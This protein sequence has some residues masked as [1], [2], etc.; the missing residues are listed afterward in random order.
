MLLSNLKPLTL[1][2]ISVS[3]LTAF[4]AEQPVE[5]APITILGEPITSPSFNDEPASNNTIDQPELIERGIN[6]IKNLSSQIANFH[7]T[8]HGIGSFGKI[9]SLRGLSDTGIFSTPSVVFYVDDVPYTSS[10][11]TMGRL[12]NI[13]SV[14]VYRSAQPGRFGKNAYAGA[15][16]IKSQQPENAIAS[17]LALELGNYSQHQ[18][19]AD[20]SGALLK[21][22]LFYSVSGNFQQRDGFLY[23]SFLNTTPDGQNLFSGR[24][25]LSWR[26]TEQWDIRLT[27]L[28]EDFDFGATRLV[29]LDS[30]D[31]YTVQS[32]ITEQLKQQADTQALR[33]AYHFDH[34]ELLSI[35]SHR[36][37]RMGPRLVDLNLTPV[38]LSRSQNLVNEAWTQEFRLHPK[39]QQ[40]W[41]WQIGAF[42][43]DEA[44]HGVMDSFTP[45]VNYHVGVQQNTIST[46]AA[47]GELAYRGIKGIKPYIDLRVDYVEN[48]INAS[49]L[50]PGNLS[51]DL[52]QSD[53]SFFVSPKWGIDVDLTPNSLLYAA[54][55]WSFKPS[56][57]TIPNIYSNLSHFNK[58]TNWHN[59]LGIKSHWFDHRFQLNLAGFYYAIDD[60]QV[61]RYF[62]QTDYGIINAP[63]AHSYGFEVESQTQLIKNL[64][65]E[66]KLGYTKT[67]FDRYSDPITGV[68]FAG[69][70]APFIPD[71]TSQI[72]LQYKHHNGYFARAEWLVTGK[73][74]FNE[75]NTQLMQ[76]NN[77]DL[78]NLRVGYD[79]NGYS[80]YLFANNLAD[81]HY[82][83]Y[84]VSNL[85]GAPGDPRLFGI[86]LGVSF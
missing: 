73:T 10:V 23:N 4:S 42:F 29:R 32:E 77:Y 48:F 34:Y 65:L 15:I 22:K 5:I 61:E 83:T 49:N 28:K 40:T 35:S 81:N 43:S 12:Y 24:A 19:T 67:Q 13:D 75:N 41:D 20:S 45:L 50:F 1:V 7:L 60:Y 79:K 71:M 16:D 46:Y 47:F 70:N 66:T 2:I 51:Y 53:N 55:G 86:R 69:K 62:T 37:W 84:K 52:K 33:V 3:S 8:D 30:P 59:E 36:L 14:S 72:A 44:K 57:Y 26:P 31:F 82:Y 78:A 39:V 11:A 58:E 54:S 80:A 56:G 68:D 25:A 17:H 6:D 64:T 74:Y 63:K 38:P 27:L 9:F 76:Q 21:N 18:V 85:R